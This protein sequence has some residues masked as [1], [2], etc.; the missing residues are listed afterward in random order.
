[1]SKEP[2]IE[3][4]PVT[5]LAQIVPPFGER[6]H[7][8]RS[9]VYAALKTMMRS[10]SRSR[11][12]VLL[13]FGLLWSGAGCV[14]LRRAKVPMDA[15]RFSP[16]GAK[17]ARGA[18]VL[19]PGFGDRPSAFVEHGFVDVLRRYAP[20]YDVIAADAHF[21]YYRADSVIERLDH[22]VIGPLRKEG[23][24]EL[25]LAGTSMG[26]HGAV[27]Y[28]RTHPE[29]VMGLLLFAPYM[30]PGDV[31]TEVER[32]GGLCKY[33]PPNHDVDDARGF[34]RANYGFLRKVTCEPSSVAVWLAVGKS[35]RLLRADQVLGKALDPKHFVTLPGGHGWKVWTPALE[36][37]AP[38]AIAPGGG[39]R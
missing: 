12:G 24:R 5:H 18:V 9:V 32:A 27:A 36:R 34:A 25:W 13:L 37:V 31:V 39:S 19:L 33:Q 7:K 6:D 11:L 29:R 35:D 4:G 38:L 23:Y 22:D 21:G 1:M 28:A 8:F 2:S 10:A 14:Y 20:E 15:V 26:G 30:G 3:R 16:H 17:R